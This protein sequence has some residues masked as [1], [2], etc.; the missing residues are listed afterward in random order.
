MK[1]HGVGLKGCEEDMGGVVEGRTTIRICYTKFI[2][3][4]K[5]T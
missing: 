1:G 3:Q 5:N 2:F 4:L